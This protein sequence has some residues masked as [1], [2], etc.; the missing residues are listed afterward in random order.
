MSRREWIV[1]GV[2]LFL[3][4]SGSLYL[5]TARRALPIPSFR[6]QM[7]SL[8][9]DWLKLTRRGSFPG[10][11]GEIALLPRT[12]AYFASAAGGWTHT[13]PWPYLQDVPLVFYGPEFIRRAGAVER[14]VTVADV[15]PTL[16]GLI[17]A[18]FNPADGSRL[19]EVRGQNPALVVTIVWD[20]GGWNVLN[21]WPD[22]WP[23]LSAMDSR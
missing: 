3:V 11:V 2:A 17:G 14:P 9:P 20:G 19:I 7:C 4:T 13:G 22:S 6:D 21:R 18:D 10:R 5:S 23:N 8:P 12:P 1:L 15:A 16:A